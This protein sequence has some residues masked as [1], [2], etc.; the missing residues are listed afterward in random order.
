MKINNRHIIAFCIGGLIG[1]ILVS[2]QIDTIS[3]IN[4]ICIILLALN[5]VEKET[6]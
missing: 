4:S 3:I 2:N 5:T 1:S 6:K